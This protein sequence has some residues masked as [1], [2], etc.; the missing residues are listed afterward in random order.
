MHLIC[1]NIFRF[2]SVLYCFVLVKAKFSGI[3]I[4]HSN[5]CVKFASVGETKTKGDVFASIC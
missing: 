1:A 3:E 2:T 5:M 4:S